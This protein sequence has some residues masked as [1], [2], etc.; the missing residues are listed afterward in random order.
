M[1]FLGVREPFTDMYLNHPWIL[2]Y[3]GIPQFWCVWL[4]WWEC[5]Q[6]S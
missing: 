6:R 5:I 1:T 4:V 2:N 3:S